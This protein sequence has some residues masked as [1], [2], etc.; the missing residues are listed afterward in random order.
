MKRRALLATALV[1]AGDSSIGS[2]GIVAGGDP[3]GLAVNDADAYVKFND[4]SA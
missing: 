3:V 2:G 4:A 1:E